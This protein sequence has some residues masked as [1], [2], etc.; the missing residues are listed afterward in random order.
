[1]ISCPPIPGFYISAHD[2]APY[3]DPGDV[4]CPFC[5]VLTSDDDVRTYSLM[6]L[7]GIELSAFY[8]THRTCASAA[9]AAEL[10]L[11]DHMV[12]GAMNAIAHQRV[13][14]T[15]STPA[16]ADTAT[17]RC[18]YV[19]QQTDARCG[20]TAGWE[21]WHGHGPEDNTQACTVH[22]GELLT[23]APEHTIVP[24]PKD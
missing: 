2:D 24:T 13:T 9:P 8:R 10:E 15:A 18:C 22:V 7:A 21:I 23:D 6:P 11:L 3:F 14:A 1:M 20:S 12:I 19:D 4:P 16:E 17:H 5:L